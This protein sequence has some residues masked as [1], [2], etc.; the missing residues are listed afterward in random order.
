MQDELANL[1]FPCLRHGLRLKERL[2]R[3]EKP[4]FAAEQAELKGLLRPANE[5]RRWPAFGGDGDQFLGVR[6]ALVCWLD[7]IFI[8][9]SPWSERWTERK[10]EES[11]YGSNDR[12]WKFWDQAHRTEARSEVDA[13]EAFYLCVMLG[14][15]GDLRDDPKKLLD[16]RDLVE[17]QLNQG[18][19]QQWAG[20]PELRPPTNVPP[21]QGRDRLRRVLIAVGAV[22]GLLI[23]VATF[24]AVYLLR[25]Y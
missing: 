25:K 24:S 19:Q 6:Y 10:L 4:D 9:D 12:A 22:L 3:G 13:L 7:E 11:L 17:G 16:W 5:A 23:P 2:E 1:V 20:P 15:R 18:K 14:F 21:L 8:L